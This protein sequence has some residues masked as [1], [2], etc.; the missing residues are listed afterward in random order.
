MA[1]SFEWDT[2]K[3][4]A[5]SAKHGVAFDEAASVF[6]DPL[7]AIFDDDAHS[8]GESREIIC[9]HSAPGRLLMVSFTERAWGI[10]RI[11]SARLATRAERKDHEQNRRP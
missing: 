7:A 2:R 11:I 9:G 5:N 6:L 10:V 1:L 4:E 3:A 8:M